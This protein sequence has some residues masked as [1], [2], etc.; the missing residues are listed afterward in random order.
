MCRHMVD[1]Q[2]A[3]TKKHDYGYMAAVYIV[4]GDVYT[5]LQ[6]CGYYSN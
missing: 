5:A 3:P 2:S 1:I 4:S 6:P